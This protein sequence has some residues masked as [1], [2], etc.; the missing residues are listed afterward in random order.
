MSEEKINNSEEIEQQTDA[1]VTAA[2]AD[3]DCSDDSCGCGHDHDHGHH[4]HDEVMREVDPAEKSLSDALS[5]SFGILKFVMVIL[6]VAYFITGLFRVDPQDKAVR[7]VFGKIIGEGDNRV[8]EQGWYFNAPFPFGQ[9]IS[10]PT[11]PQKVVMNSDFW[12]A[13]K[14]S[15][16]GKKPSQLARPLKPEI[17]GSLITGDANLVHG[18]FEVSYKVKDFVKFIRSIGVVETM[19]LNDSKMA[20][21]DEIVKQAVATGVVH[22]VAEVE[23]DS[24]IVGRT[25]REAAK[26]YAQKILDDLNSGIEIETVDNTQFQMP[27]S[28]YNAW[29]AVSNA[30]N[31]RGKLIEVAKQD[32]AKILGETAGEAHAP[33][34][35]LVREYQLALTAK[36]AVKINDF[37]NQ[38]DVALRTLRVKDTEDVTYNIGGQAA[39]VI[40]QAESYKTQ[41][42]EQIKGEAAKF[43]TLY[44]K[45]VENPVIF[46]TR[47][48]QEALESIFKSP[49]VETVFAPPG[50]LYL[51]T[52]RD[53]EVT[54]R[55]EEAKLR[56]LEQ[57]VSE[58][59]QAN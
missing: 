7:L 16:V 17:D 24:Y 58:Q 34:Y 36:D 27:N 5:V 55:R 32:R 6:V 13:M 30:E 35:R 10:V 21:A 46:K 43:N 8:L 56:A 42:V 4:H 14:I 37:E 19:T 31:E 2:V 12:Y 25:N 49:D 54:R 38:I 9:H 53:P 29:E 40:K 41:V 33:L 26:R 47:L 20:R 50:Q 28:V 45:Y 11:D 48:R 22:A 3:K 51:E 23:A 44:L 18:R 39:A 59:G 15:D 1:A 57:R 52:N